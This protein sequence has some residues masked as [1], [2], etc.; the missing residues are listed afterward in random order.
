[1]LEQKIY[2]NYKELCGAMGWEIYSGGNTKKK[3]LKELNNLCNYH[4]EGNKFIIDEVFEN[5]ILVFDNKRS[6]IMNELQ[7]MIFYLALKE[8]SNELIISKNRLLIALGLLNVNFMNIMC[9][10]EKYAEYRNIPTY[11]VNEVISVAYT[12][13]CNHLNNTL[14]KLDDMSL[15]R[16]TKDVISVT[17]QTG[18]NRLATTDEIAHIL[19]CETTILKEYGVENRN[20]IPYF[21]LSNFKS[22]VTYL[23]KGKGIRNYYY[24]Y[25]IIK[26]EDLSKC[27]KIPTEEEVEIAF[28]KVNN[29]IQNSTFKSLEKK[30]L[31]YKDMYTS[32]EELEEILGIKFNDTN[33]PNI[34]YQELEELN[35][36]LSNIS[37]RIFDLMLDDRIN[38]PSFG[39]IKYNIYMSKGFLDNSKVII[40][41]SINKDRDKIDL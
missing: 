5:P 23:L 9:H 6:Q 10:K 32:V 28:A 20:S 18:E 34:D 7:T 12:R 39:D 1:M 29:H 11:Q 14:K 21:E 15:F 41:D 24:S 13:I 17:L 27:V 4:K 19:K 25:R 8:G 2:K 40:D 38:L 33:N 31:S 30:L 26:N 3:Q 36:E 22:K 37:E 16:T 35:F